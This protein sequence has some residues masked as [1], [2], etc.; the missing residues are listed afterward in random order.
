MSSK[1]LL[2][3]VCNKG[4]EITTATLNGGCVTNALR[5]LMP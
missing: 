2:C 4:F 1:K 5:K 3:D